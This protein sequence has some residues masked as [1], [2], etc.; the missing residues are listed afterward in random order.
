ML[1]NI[2]CYK[3]FC[4]PYLSFKLTVN[5]TLLLSERNIYLFLWYKVYIFFWYKVTY[6]RR[7]CNPVIIWRSFRKRLVN[8][9]FTVCVYFGFRYNCVWNLPHSI[10]NSARC[11]NK[12]PVVPLAASHR[13]IVATRLD[14][15]SSPL[16]AK[17]KV[18]KYLPCHRF[19]R[20]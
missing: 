1:W 4:L 9:E 6:L 11:Y 16:T 19:W 5:H 20:R 3:H 7:I 14:A 2:K 13:W 8:C 15:T 12:S 18:S 17:T 10:R